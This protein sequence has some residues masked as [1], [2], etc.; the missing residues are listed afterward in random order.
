[1]QYSYNRVGSY[2]HAEF[3]AQSMCLLFSWCDFYPFFSELK[4]FIRNCGGGL[5]MVVYACVSGV[6]IVCDL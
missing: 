2:F 5:D 3:H 4:L 1:M 6:I